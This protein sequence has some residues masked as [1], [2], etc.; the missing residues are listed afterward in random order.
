MPTIY[1]RLLGEGTEVWRPVEA[2]TQGNEL[3]RLLG[4][5]EPGEEWEFEPGALVTAQ[6]HV[7]TSGETAL[8]AVRAL[9]PNNSSKPTPLR[10]AA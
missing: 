10:G 6:P 7:F 2:E 1:V 3:F 5:V 8:V 9:P 4:F